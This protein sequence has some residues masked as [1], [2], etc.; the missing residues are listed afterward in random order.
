MNKLMAR[1]T[2]ASLEA[3]PHCASHTV[4]TTDSRCRYG[5]RWRRKACAQ[6]KHRW[7]TIE[8]YVDDRASLLDAIARLDAAQSACWSQQSSRARAP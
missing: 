2:T 5:R 4:I 8:I 1:R 3:C 6:C 7:S